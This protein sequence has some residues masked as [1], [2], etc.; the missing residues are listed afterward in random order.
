[1][2][3]HLRGGARTYWSR[4]GD[5][6]RSGAVQAARHAVDVYGESHKSQSLHKVSLSV[7]QNLVVGGD[8]PGIKAA[9]ASDIIDDPVKGVDKAQGDGGIA[10]QLHGELGE[11]GV[12]F[13]VIFYAS[14]DR[15]ERIDLK[16]RRGRGVG[17]K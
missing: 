1:M 7:V 5:N 3:C 17:R 8:N 6:A 10:D 14:G 15:R 9:L 12:G 4:N 11:D 13:F 16:S 2:S